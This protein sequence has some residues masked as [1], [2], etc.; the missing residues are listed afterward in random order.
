MKEGLGLANFEVLPGTICH[1]NWVL[2]RDRERSDNHLV[3]SLDGRWMY[4]MIDFTHGFTGPD[5]TADA[6]EQGSY[7]RVWMPTHRIVAGAVRG[8]D[9]L[10]PTL[11]R[12]EAVTD[13]EIEDVLASMPKFGG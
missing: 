6:L 13:T 11:D 5:W 2:T 12:I 1:D 8:L 7:L 3:R 4:V 10:R 9:S